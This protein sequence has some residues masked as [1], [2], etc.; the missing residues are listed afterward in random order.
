MNKQNKTETDS[1]IEKKLMVASGQEVE[2]WEF[3]NK[4]V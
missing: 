4:E 2:G 3:K 1:H